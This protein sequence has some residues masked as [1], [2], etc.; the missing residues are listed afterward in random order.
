MRD[1]KA[2][3]DKVWHDG[4]KVKLRRVSA[5]PKLTRTLESFLDDRR[6]SVK[7]NGKLGEEFHITAGVPQGSCISPTLYNV[8]VADMPNPM[9]ESTKNIVYADDVTQIISSPIGT[10]QNKVE[11]E[12]SRLNNFEK[13]WKI[14]TNAKKFKIIATD[15]KRPDFRYRTGHGAIHAERSGKFLGF[16]ILEA[17]TPRA[18]K[19]RALAAREGLQKLRRF[20]F[21]TPKAK[22]KLY[23]SKIRTAMT[24]PICPWAGLTAREMLPLQT[25]QNKALNFIGNYQWQD[26]V[27]A[28][29]KH[30]EHKV[31]PLS[32]FI[33]GQN[34]RIWAKLQIISEDQVASWR[35]QGIRRAPRFKRKFRS[36]L[37]ATGSEPTDFT[38]LQEIQQ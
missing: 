26:M 15:R 35:E 27:R 29:T 24:Y 22:R 14:Q 28:R 13:K 32:L 12:I 25:I 17:G 19:I 30:Q 23:L 3:F 21:M 18:A 1:V 5:P 2:A 4:L 9:R 34:R 36:S 10:I 6:A 20:R 11:Q 8:Y 37:L 33:K 16:R 31:T 7:I 38:T